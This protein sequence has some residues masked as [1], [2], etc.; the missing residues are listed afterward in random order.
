MP[1]NMPTGWLDGLRG[2]GRLGS[3]ADA[4]TVEP[5]LYRAV[6]LRAD[7]I[8]SVPSRLLRNGEKVAWPWQSN[9][10]QLIRDTERSLLVA[11]A[12]YWLRVID[13]RTLKGFVC[14]N[15]MQ[16]TFTWSPADT[17]ITDPYK[18][19]RFTVTHGGKIYGPWT[20]DQIVYFREPSFTD[21]Y[22][23]GIAPAA[24]ALKSAQ[25][26]HYVT[27]FQGNFFA[28]GAQPVTVF[29]LPEGT[30]DAEMQR[31]SSDMNNRIGQGIINAFKTVVLRA[32]E[33]KVQILTP[34]LDTMRMPELTQQ[35]TTAICA[36]LGVPR[37]MLEA[38]A[39]NYATADSDR[40]SFWRETVVPR[41][42]LYAS[43]INTQ[44]M[45]PI[46]YT[47]EWMPETMDVFQVDEQA[48]AS[49]F[50]AYTQGGIPPRAAAKLLGID[51]LDEY[52]PEAQAAPVD[53]TPTL[54][55]TTAAIPAALPEP[56]ADAPPPIAE[57]TKAAP[58]DWAL[59]SKKIER[60]IKSGRAP[61]CA[62]DSSH[63]A[64]ADVDAVMARCWKGMTVA[65]IAPIVDA[66][67]ASVADLTPDEKRIY[68]RIIGEMRKRGTQWAKDIYDGKTPDTALNDVIKPVLD[69]ELGVTMGKRLDTLGATFSIPMD[70]DTETRYIQNWLGGYTPTVVG[71]IDQTT[72][73]RI[74]P[75]IDM[76]RTTPG[77][78]LA[79]LETAVLPLSDPVR[80]KMIA[81]TETTRAY[82]Q[83]TATYRDY[84]GE[85]G[86][87]MERVW[88]TENDE[89]VR[90]CPICYPLDKKPESEW[91]AD[92]ADGPPGHVNCRCDTSLR[93][94]R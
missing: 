8:A 53:V 14:L 38:S 55:E 81:I 27:T 60:R 64:A 92:Q 86:I 89:I 43:V 44:L 31:F 3:A 79:D 58:D 50:L 26:M 91:P 56:I 28:S 17:S 74:A 93:V 45:A 1:I 57:P 35:A 42:S 20:T 13:G 15:P 77:M 62:F 85:R 90:E 67:K 34:P 65:D 2:S 52:W 9:F 70:T 61:H 30:P 18:G 24:V 33:L 84:L 5:M 54:P 72:A 41:L 19:L 51:M 6:N 46:K 12:A 83:S 59:L 88:N 82:S 94:V 36:A 47:V 39:A 7:A 32:Q 25:L 37:T 29:N 76:Y 4:Y 87:R 78:T 80:A 66:V 63:I 68:D 23:P 21:T 10:E 49:S 11:G 22:T 16:V 48:R 71:K 73:D 40:Q 69:T 75:L